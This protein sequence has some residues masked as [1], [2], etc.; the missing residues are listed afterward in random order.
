MKTPS[1]LFVFLQLM[2]YLWCIFCLSSCLKYLDQIW[3][4]CMQ[5]TSDLERIRASG[6]YYFQRTVLCAFN[7][8]A[9]LF[10]TAKPI[11][12]K[13]QSR[14]LKQP[15]AWRPILTEM[16]KSILKPKP[17][18]EVEA[19]AGPDFYLTPAPQAHYLVPLLSHTGLYNAKVSRIFPSP[20]K[21]Y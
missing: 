11:S 18:C 14:L 13:W 1:F 7:W 12:K 15:P 21:F 20:A 8:S 16:P 2:L 6:I 17:G 5:S 4:F 19:C 10:T 3:R 9:T